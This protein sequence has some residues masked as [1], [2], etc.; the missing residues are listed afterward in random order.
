MADASGS[1]SSGGGGGGGGSAGHGGGFVGGGQHSRYQQAGIRAAGQQQPGGGAAVGQNVHHMY[2]A[3][4]IGH[5]PPLP[6]MPV[7]VPLP[8]YVAPLSVASP[9]L[10]PA[11]HRAQS[12]YHQMVPSSNEAFQDWSVSNSNIAAQNVARG[13]Q[14]DWRI[15]NASAL[16]MPFAGMNN[17][18][19][20]VFYPNLA[21]ASCSIN[22]TWPATNNN[23]M[24][25]NSLYTYPPAAIENHQQAPPFHNINHD[26]N[27][28][29][30]P[31]FRG[32]QSFVPVSSFPQLT[33]SS[34]SYNSTHQNS[35][36][37]TNA[38]KKVK[39][40]DAKEPAGVLIRSNDMETDK[41]DELLADHPPVSD[42]LAILNQNQNQNHEPFIARFNCREYHLIL[43]KD[44][45]NSDV[46]NIGRIVLPKRDAEAYL[47]PLFQREGLGLVMDDF[48]IPTTWNFKYRYAYHNIV[49]DADLTSARSN[50]V[51]SMIQ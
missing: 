15:P 46:G 11:P 19:N 37:P 32:D 48:K 3:G 18:N 10:P 50:I 39:K 14:Q 23:S 13:F 1:P 5:H 21:P 24:P 8:S 27:S 2:P 51:S 35:N 44:L 36:E 20:N 6:T 9:P 40:S 28:G 31:S 29:F 34:Q 47:P 7:Q 49:G 33:S 26:T 12:S 45:T 25:M 16:F 42:E 43:R 22:I 30:A 41:S 17:A 38:S 4:V